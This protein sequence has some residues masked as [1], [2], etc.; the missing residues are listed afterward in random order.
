MATMAEQVVDAS[1]LATYRRWRGTSDWDAIAAIHA[2]CMKADGLSELMSA[3]SFERYLAAHDPANPG[4]LVTLA[5]IA[6][7]PVGFAYAHYDKD[8][9]EGVR[10]IW[11]RCRVVPERRRMGIGREL[12]GRAQAT[13]REHAGQQSRTDLPLR[14]ETRADEGET[15]AIALLEGEG[16]APIRWGYSMVRATLEDLP[17]AELPEGLDARPVRRE[18]A[19]RILEARSEASVDEWYYPD[20]TPEALAATID[21]PIEGQLD[22][23]QVAW[24]GDEVVGGVLGYIDPDENATFNRRRGYTESIFTRR[25]WRGRGVATALIGRNL[26]LLRDRGMTEAALFVDADNP[27]GALPLYE[28]CGFVRDRTEITYGRLAD[29]GPGR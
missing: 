21:D 6:G 22:V 19:G 12:L 24:D 27:T 11:T 17:A 1:G 29:S 13:G 9:P 7:E 20:F 10:A 2:A 16:Y 23:W 5:E 28:R 14:F 18:D 3:S 4:G 15:G 8:R 25:R 26:R